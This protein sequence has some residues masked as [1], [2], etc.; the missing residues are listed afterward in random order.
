MRFKEHDKSAKTA[1]RK[2]MLEINWSTWIFGETP[3]IQV[4]E[5]SVQVTENEEERKKEKQTETKAAIGI[6]WLTFT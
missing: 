4:R 2:N 3:E 5:D 1:K 6:H